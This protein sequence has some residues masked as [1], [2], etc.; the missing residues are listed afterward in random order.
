MTSALSLLTGFGVNLLIAIIIVRFIYYPSKQ[1]KNYVFTFVAFNTI[2]FLVMGLLTSIEIGVGA[3]FGLFAI[4]S[5]LRYRT[6]P[7]PPREMTYLFI[8]IALPVANSVLIG[9]GSWDQVWVANGL[10][11][12]VIYVL[13]QGWGFR[14]EKSTSII[15][16]DLELVK[17]QNHDLLLGDLRQRTGL[18]L[19]RCEVGRLNFAKGT[20]EIKLYYEELGEGGWLNA[21]ILNPTTYQETETL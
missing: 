14:Y 20:A 21:G 7:M 17:V 11:M 16:D 18:P 10:I 8:M 4:F 12:G 1:N 6:S 9:N 3:G 19:K 13:E 15:Y 2:I 5:V